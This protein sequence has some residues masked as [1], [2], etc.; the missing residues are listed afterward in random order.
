MAWEASHGP[1]VAAERDAARAA[2]HF[3]HGFG[4]D[5]R[6]RVHSGYRD[7]L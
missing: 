4:A 6:P 2:G 5:G 7:F 1:R 3:G